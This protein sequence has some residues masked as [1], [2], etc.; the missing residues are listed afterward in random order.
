M[1]QQSLRLALAAAGYRNQVS[2]RMY[3]SNAATQCASFT[4]KFTSPVHLLLA[5]G[6]WSKE[7]E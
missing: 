5:S 7:R 3:S 6:V 1:T 4:S 2:P